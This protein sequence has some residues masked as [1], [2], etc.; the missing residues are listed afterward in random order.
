M[1]FSA[2]AYVSESVADPLLY[3]RNNTAATAVLLQTILNYQPLPFVFSS[4]CATYGIPEKLP[5]SEDHPQRPINA[6]G[7]SK[8]MVEWMLKDCASA[9]DLTWVALRYF[10]AAGSDPDGMVGEVH[11]PETHLIPLALQA[12]RD[13]TSGVGGQRGALIGPQRLAFHWVVLPS[14][15]FSRACG[16]AVSIGPN[17]PLSERVRRPWRWSATPALSSSAGHRASSVTRASQ[18][19]IW[20]HS[21]LERGKRSLV[22]ISCD[23]QNNCSN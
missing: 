15:V 13:G 4:T 1:H 3:Y 16:T 11:E 14:G 9:H 18:R 10:N 20:I 22:D 19:G 7:R 23:W 12:A 21:P 8:L 6:Y 2:Y 5:I 17:M